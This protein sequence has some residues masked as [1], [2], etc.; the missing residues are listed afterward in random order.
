MDFFHTLCL[1]PPWLLV[2]LFFAFTISFICLVFTICICH[3]DVRSV[4]MERPRLSCSQLYLQCSGQALVSGGAQKTVALEKA[5]LL[6][7]PQFPY[8][9][10]GVKQ[11]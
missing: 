5:H 11:P 7:K 8:L 2:K 10:D 9:Q 1:F 4:R 3:P 6:S